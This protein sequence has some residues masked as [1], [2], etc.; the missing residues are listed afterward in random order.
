MENKPGNRLLAS[1][2]S[3]ER[4]R[5]AGNLPPSIAAGWGA[6]RFSHNRVPS[7]HFLISPPVASDRFAFVPER[8][9]KMT[10]PKIE[11][12][13]IETADAIS[14]SIGRGSPGFLRLPVLR[15]LEPEPEQTKMSLIPTG[16]PMCNMV[17]SIES[18]NKR[19]RIPSDSSS[20]SSPPLSDSALPSPLRRRSMPSS[21]LS[22]LRR[23]K[24]SDRTR[25][26]ESLMPWER[27]M[28]TGTML[29][30][31]YKYVRFLEAQVAALYTM[32]VFA[33]FSAAPVSSGRGGALGGLEQLNR[34]QMLQVVV[35]S[36]RIQ[37]KLYEKGLCV[38]CTEQVGALRRSVEDNHSPASAA[39]NATG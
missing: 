17:S 8:Q 9:P 27:R 16:I 29:G 15:S 2:S 37:E 4:P 36:P 39:S 33:K 23:K 7:S 31:A 1:R 24:I 14:I 6:L 25:I 12:L 19:I 22:R 18:P 35:N 20:A 5:N 38:F 21:E 10:T 30:E 34:Q 26:I 32:P 28:D 13:E 11:P 3:D